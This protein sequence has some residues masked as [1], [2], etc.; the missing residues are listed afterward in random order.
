MLIGYARVP[1]ADGQG[2]ALQLKILKG[3][4][5]TRLFDRRGPPPLTQG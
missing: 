4:G 1:K 5:S 3:A 2:N